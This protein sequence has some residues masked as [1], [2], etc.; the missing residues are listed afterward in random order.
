[1][2]NSFDNCGFSFFGIPWKRKKEEISIFET[3]ISE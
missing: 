3:L 2:E 1:V